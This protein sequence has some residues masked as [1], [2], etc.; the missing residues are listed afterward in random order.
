ML[1][2]CNAIPTWYGYVRRRSPATDARRQ[3]RRNEHPAVLSHS[4]HER[5]PYD[6]VDRK[7]DTIAHVCS[8][9]LYAPSSSSPGSVGVHAPTKCVR[10]AAPA[11]GCW[12]R[13]AVEA[14]RKRFSVHFLGDDTGKSAT[15]HTTAAHSIR[16][17]CTHC[18]NAT[19]AY[20]PGMFLP[21][22]PR[23]RNC[24]GI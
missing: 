4:I 24:P 11:L 16:R 7:T 14:V 15:G 20:D 9:A 5:F 1:L 21:L 8:T 22:F 3:R 13:E 17:V 2:L 6:F 12:Y 18:C 10:F 19:V 23:S